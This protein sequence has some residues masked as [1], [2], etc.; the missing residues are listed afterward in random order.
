MSRIISRIRSAIAAGGSTNTGSVSETGDIII[1]T[2]DN[3]NGGE[4]LEMSGTIYFKS[5]YPDLASSLGLLANF[6]GSEGSIVPDRNWRAIKRNGN[7]VILAGGRYVARS[8]DLGETWSEIDTQLPF[9]N[10][11][12]GSG[13]A[14]ANGTWVSMCS[15]SPYAA[16]STDDG[17]SW[18]LSNQITSQN[19]PWSNLV[20]AGGRFIA[21]AGYS[22]VS[23]YS[24]DGITWTETQMPTSEYWSGLAYSPELDI[25]LATCDITS[26]RFATSVDG[27]SWS[28]SFQPFNINWRT[29]TWGNDRFC[30]VADN[31]KETAVSFDGINWEYGTLPGSYRWRSLAWGGGYFV[32]LA[33]GASLGAYSD[34]GLEWTEFSIPDGNWASI[35]YL[36]NDNFLATGA[37][38]HVII[39]PKFDYNTETQFFIPR[40]TS[41]LGTVYIKT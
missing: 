19:I 24:S 28:S 25:V 32:T 33:S 13:L 30:V 11:N 22:N 41:N 2:I 34:D 8:T 27:V 17:I 40:R 37:E 4:Y 18:N 21:I 1:S 6:G 36:G 16:Y 39:V 31:S 23:A 29:A 5:T 3:K 7:T 20:W 10:D 14:Y 15:S 35:E 12:M 26:T 9:P 38:E